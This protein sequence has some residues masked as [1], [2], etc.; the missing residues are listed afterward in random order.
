MYPWYQLQLQVGSLSFRLGLFKV[1]HSF[2]R[3]AGLFKALEAAYQALQK[4]TQTFLK[5]PK[6][7][8]FLRGFHFSLRL[9]TFPGHPMKSIVYRSEQR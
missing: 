4:F 7:G 3:K 1:L 9:C 5:H 2:P 8:S 6:G